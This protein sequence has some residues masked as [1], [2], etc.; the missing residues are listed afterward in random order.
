M[1]QY[2]NSLKKLVEENYDITVLD[3][4]KLKNVYKIVAV[5]GNFCLKQFKYDIYRLKHIFE[6]FDYLKNNNFDN[7][8]DIIFTYSGEKYVE[9]NGIY[10]YMTIWVESRELNY[11]NNYDVIKAAQYIAKFHK[12]SKGFIASEDTKPDIRW[13][14]WIE[15]F[16][17]KINDISKFKEFI[18]D[19]SE[20]S[21]FDKIY[22]K[23][24]E[25]NIEIAN[26]SI[27]NLYKFDYENVMNEYTKKFYICHHDL[28]N[29]NI[30]LD[31]FGK[32]YL[33]DF[34]YVIL[35]TYLHDL[36]SFIMRCLKFGRWNNEKFET[37]I[38][39][40]KSIKYVSEQEISIVMS[41]ILFPNDFWQ[42]GF[43]YYME[44]INWNVEKFLK[45]LNRSE[46]DKIDRRNFIR[47]L[48]A[49]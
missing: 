2:I 3:M 1:I 6:V 35:D 27:E 43:Q 40:Y 17:K 42:I 12:Y 5:E 20:L 23:N 7:I 37:I 13:M 28:A 9:L 16:E 38:D 24:I 19:K 36:G 41:F 25:K 32:I 46:N 45:R 39:S 10:F 33:I 44:K 49:K 34:D 8:L 26:E 48:I 31:S 18:D 14:K 30:L 4:T 29:H 47:S 21:T 11:S 15:I 22:S